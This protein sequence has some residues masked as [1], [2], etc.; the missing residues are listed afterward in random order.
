MIPQADSPG[1]T[2]LPATAGWQQ[3]LSDCI[4]DPRELMAVLALDPALL[5]AAL[6]ADRLFRLRVPR[7][8]VR[9]MERG[10][11]ADPLLRQVLPLDEELLVVP[12]YT[13]DPLAEQQHTR[14]PGLLQKYR[15]RVLVIAA[16]ACAV[17]CRYCFRR[18][19]PYADNTPDTGR[20]EQ[21]LAGL[22]ADPSIEEVILSGGDPLLVSNR[23]L[24]WIIGRLADIPHLQRLR[25]HTRLPVVIP[26]RVDGKL[27]GILAG[28]R[29]QAVLVTHANHPNEIDDG[30]AAAM[31]RLAAAGITLLNQA[32]LL[33]GVNDNADA[34]AALSQK[35]FA[36]R[37]L[38]YYL[39]LLDPVAGAAHFD[40]DEAAALSLHQALASRLPG[41][42]VPRLVREIPGRPGKTPVVFRW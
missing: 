31:H 19:Y 12:G 9:R 41:Y 38:P 6:A 28:T 1:Q 27:P 21:M 8:F 10:N 35:L 13:G 15:G 16:G 32:V 39:H 11:P 33:R 7:D 26:E 2:L 18:E 34:L 24:A 30:V 5:P 37:V 29:L 20:W 14:E 25:V 22:A 3:A 17:N 40:V 23:R 36:A 4:T 42:L